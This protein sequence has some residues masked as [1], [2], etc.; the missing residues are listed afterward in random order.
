MHMVEYIHNSDMVDSLEGV[1]P[2]QCALMVID[3]LGEVEGTPLEGVLLEPTNNIA[4]LC[5]I[6]RKK[7]IPVVFANDAHYEGIDHELELWGRHGIA[8]SPEAQPSP[9]LELQEGDFVVEKSKYSAF[10]QTRMRTLLQDLGVKTIVMCGFD[11]NICVKHTAADAY[12]NHFDIVVVTDAT[13]TFL[14]GDQAEGLDYMKKCYA[15]RL[16]T[17]DEVAELFES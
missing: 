1:D 11:T 12:F 8:G 10:F 7:G 6:A 3:A 4:R 9:Q 5:R 15:A 14:I 17:T 16:A 13:G 2:S